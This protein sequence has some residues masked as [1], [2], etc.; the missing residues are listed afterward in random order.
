MTLPDSADR[1][2]S[3]QL[4][5]GRGVDTARPKMALM[6][7]PPVTFRCTDVY[8]GEAELFDLIFGKIG[9]A[10]RCHCKPEYAR[11]GVKHDVINMQ[12]G[13]AGW[14]IERRLC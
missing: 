10:G 6:D 5:T 3:W 13:R 12:A 9:F 7:S 2:W 8:Q 4:K 11:L 1:Q 14:R